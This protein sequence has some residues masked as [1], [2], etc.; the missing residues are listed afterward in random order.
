MTT[1]ETPSRP[2]LPDV[3]VSLGLWQDRP[4]SEVLATATIADQLGFAELWIGEMA[5]WD[6]F[7]LATAI[8]Q[9]T[10]QIPLTIGPLSVHVRDPMT[11][12][13]G[14]ASV[15]ELT[16]RTVQIA[17]GTSSPVVVEEWH[18]RPRPRPALALRESVAAVR[19]LLAGERSSSSG[20]VVSS[21]GYRLRLTPTNAPLTVAAFGDVAVSVAATMGDRMVLNLVTP[22]S[23]AR[24]VAKMREVADRAGRPAP[25][26]ALWATAAADPSPA[27]IDQLRRGAVAYLGVPGYAEMF[28][29]AG[30]ADLV[31]MA[32]RRPH[33]SELLAATPAELVQAVGLV[34]DQ[35]A[36]R[37][38]LAAYAA[39]GVDQVAIVP[40][41]TDDDPAG[42]ATMHAVMEATT[43]VS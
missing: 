43:L 27:A 23:A 18:G 32:R 28:I 31:A 36:I 29:E 26:V 22:A 25:K 24:L 35:E 7:V 2:E 42:E 3:A 1:N 6:A 14:A 12:A 9:R 40:S 21:R 30:F 41:A 10:D 34:G 13:V 4:P 20:E 15:A 16:G 38:K 8:G 37:S 17:L 39:A 5:T 19:S 33:P 11:I